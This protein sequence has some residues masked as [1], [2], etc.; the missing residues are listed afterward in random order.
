MNRNPLRTTARM[1][2]VLAAGGLVAA[3]TG[4]AAA[5]ALAADPQPIH[6]HQI[7]GTVKSVNTGAKSF[8]VD[9]STPDDVKHGDVTVQLPNNLSRPGKAGQHGQGKAKSHLAAS[10]DDVK[11]GTRVVVQGTLESGKFNARRVHVLPAKEITHAVGEVQSY[12]NGTL[13]VKLADNSTKT[14]K[15]TSD[16]KFHPEGKSAANLT[17]PG[18]KVTVVAKDG[19]AKNIVFL[20]S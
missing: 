1:R 7:H 14:F 11:V 6:G 4:L 13:T 2:V 10:I 9:T 3:F 5:P 12:T 20:A 16:T 18:A 8:V 19:E 17:P 15:V